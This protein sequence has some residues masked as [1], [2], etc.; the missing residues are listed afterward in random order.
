MET[1]ALWVLVKERWRIVCYLKSLPLFKEM[2]TVT[3]TNHISESL[4]AASARVDLT[5]QRQVGHY[6]MSYFKD[7]GR[8]QKGRNSMEAIYSC[9]CMQRCYCDDKLQLNIE[10]VSIITRS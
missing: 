9:Q 5:H 4:F 6:S 7:D 10:A 2:T 1:L 8:C 3:R